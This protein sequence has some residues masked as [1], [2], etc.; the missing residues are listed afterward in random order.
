MKNFQWKSLLPHVIAIVVFLIVAA[1][2]CKPALDGK[3]LQQ[4]DVI[5]WKGMVKDM[6]IYKDKHGTWPLW[7]NGMFSGMPGYQIAM[8]SSNP[9]SIGYLQPVFSLFLSKPISFFFLASLCF[10]FLTQCLRTNPYLGIIGGLAYAYATYNPIIIAVGHDTKMAAIAYM[11]ALIG[12]LIL[13]YEKRYLWGAA[14]TGISTCFLIGANHLQITYYAFIIVAIM[15]I[16]YAVKWIMQKDFKTLFIAAGT[17]AGAIVLGVLVNAVMLLTTYEYSKETIRG[18]SVLADGKTSVTKTGLSTDYALSYSMYKTEP[19]VLMFPKM[20][21]GSSSQ[22]EVAEDKSKA[23]EALQQMPQQLG[24]QI[25]QMGGLAFYWGGIDGVGTSGPPYTGAIICFLALIGFVLLD[26]KHK[27]WILATIVLAFMMSWGKYFEGFNI[28]LLKHLPMYDK[29]RAP[30]MIMVVPNLLLCMLAVLT[31]QKVIS[32]DNKEELWKKYK[33]GLLVVGG[34]IVVALLVYWGADFTGVS[35]KQITSRLNE[36]PDGQQKDAIMQYVHPFFNGLKED[37]KNLFTSDLLRSILFMAVAGVAIWLSIK[38]KL[39]Y[40]FVLAAIGV[41]ALIDVL[42]IDT[43]YLN[44]ANYAEKEESDNRFTPSP[45]NTAI[46]KDTSYYRVLDLSGG[47]S[48]AFNA[49]SLTSYFH[50]SIGGYHPAKLSIYQDLIEHQLYKYPDCEPVINMLNA[51]YIMTGNIATDTVANKNALGAAWFVKTIKYEN[52]PSAVMNAL[53]TFNPKDTAIADVKDKAAIT[54]FNQTDSAA[55]I[56]LINNDNDVVNYVSNNGNNGFAV[57]SE[58]YYDKGWKAY[59][60]DKET[61]IVK[62][63]YVL[64]GLQ[65]PSGKHNIRFEF[66][67]ASYYSGSKAAIFSSALIWLLIIGAIAQEFRKSKKAVA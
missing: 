63:N 65:V 40:G 55:N 58:V 44:E 37:R 12:S 66:K 57:F 31:V 3:V 59:I 17:A 29:F 62:V 8:G 61:P 51:K 10:Y 14:L 23:V 64:R 43:K 32:T 9:I 49:G 38:K 34:V 36:I 15:S 67:P 56:Q 4:S 27:W 20:F 50:K 25:Q 46:L 24:Q 2:Y 5:H 42:T 54:A 16:G 45:I 22:L 1:I 48:S 19:L 6:E 30:S 33:K 11:P 13:I 35:D 60:D 47:I 28:F 52:G 21:G 39:H 41:F 26:S 18:G 53:T 7:T